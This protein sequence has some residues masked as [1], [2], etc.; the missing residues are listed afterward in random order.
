[1]RTAAAALAAVSA[2]LWALALAVP[3]DLQRDLADVAAAAMTGG[4]AAMLWALPWAVRRVIAT[5][6]A[7]RT[8]GDV[9]DR[10]TQDGGHRPAA[11]LRQ[12]R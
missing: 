6:D 3:M 11:Y 12:V 8:L 9:I 1:M 7:I 4:T 5:R 10:L 2:T